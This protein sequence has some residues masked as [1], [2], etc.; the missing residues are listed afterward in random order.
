MGLLT[1]Y[2]ISPTNSILD[3]HLDAVLALLDELFAAPCI[4]H[5]AIDFDADHVLL[6]R[7]WKRQRNVTLY[8]ATHF[9]NGTVARAFDVA[10]DR[11]RRR[12]STSRALAAIAILR[13]SSNPQI[14]QASIDAER[15][16]V[17]LRHVD[18]TV[19]T[20]TLA[21]FPMAHQPT[22]RVA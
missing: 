16:Q 2:S 9:L 12:D 18:A 1:P 22:P 15:E 5:C 13:H 6:S 3:A 10:D 7:R 17:I 8:T 21:Q 20:Y 4:H 19:R 11:N 14:C